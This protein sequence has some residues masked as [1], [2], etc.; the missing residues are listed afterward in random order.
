MQYLTLEYT[1]QKLMQS[2][3]LLATSLDAGL[4]GP[5]RLHDLF[6]N[7]EAMTP[8][9]FK[10]QGAGLEIDYG[11]SSSPFGTCLLAFTNRGICH[12]GFVGKGDQLNAL[13][14]LFETWPGAT[15]AER[16]D[17]V[18]KVVYRIFSTDRHRVDKRR[19][20]EIAGR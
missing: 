10:K 3:S 2:E 13:T 4:S 1:K 14:G 17:P 11:F 8:G 6:V 7:F 5:G 18:R 9:E 20:S 12:L 16:S 19:F 15:F